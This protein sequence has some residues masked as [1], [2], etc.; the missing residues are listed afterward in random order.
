MTIK[1]FFEGMIN[2]QWTLKEVI[3]ILV[4]TTVIS[5]IVTPFIGIPVGIG[6]FY[7]FNISEEEKQAMRHRS[8]Y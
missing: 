8:R 3:L 1:Q 2:R 6:I 7:Y 4:Y 5:M